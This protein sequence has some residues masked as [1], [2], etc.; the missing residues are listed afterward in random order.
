MHKVDLNCDLGEGFNDEE[1][2]ELI[3]S[4]NIACTYHAGSEEIIKKT[5]EICEKNNIA[6]GAHP[7]YR[8][9]IN[10]GRKE[11]IASREEIISLVYNQLEIISKYTNKM[12]HVK[13]HGALYNMASKD[14]DIASA[15]VEA[16]YNFDKRLVILAPSGSKLINKA[17]EKGLKIAR[18]AFADRAYNE[19]GSLVS[20]DK[21]DSVLYDTDLIKKRVINMIKLNKV[22]AINGKIIP[23]KLD[24]ICV[25]SDTKNA[26]NI[27]KEIKESLKKH[28]IN[29]ESLESI[30]GKY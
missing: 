2:I 21:K 9:R 27:I 29:I 7:S 8:D 1:I 12:R 20:R 22:E 19:D 11:I 3:S 28:F 14:S 5:V 30:Y 18:E 23:I 16:V 6:I 4:A 17:K 15:I 24:S 13:P 26:I 25:H 10:F